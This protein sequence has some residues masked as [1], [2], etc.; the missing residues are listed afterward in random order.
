M[1]GFSCRLDCVV[2]SNLSTKTL[3]L[4]V[5]NPSADCAAMP[6]SIPTPQGC[7]NLGDSGHRLR[8]V[9][10]SKPR[11]EPMAICDLDHHQN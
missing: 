1:P 3:A 10:A 9:R 8:L 5:V 6:I 7:C 4:A 2:L 11:A